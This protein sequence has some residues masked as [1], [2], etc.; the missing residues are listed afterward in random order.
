MLISA[1]SLRISQDFPGYGQISIETQVFL[2]S[3]CVYRTEM[4]V[5]AQGS[6]IDGHRRAFS[7][8]FQPFS[9]LK[10]HRRTLSNAPTPSP[11]PSTALQLGNSPANS[12][13]PKETS[14]LPLRLGKTEDNCEGQQAVGWERE[15]GKGKW[16]KSAAKLKRKRTFLGVLD[17]AISYFAGSTANSSAE[18]ASKRPISALKAHFQCLEAENESLL[19]A[20]STLQ[21]QHQLYTQHISSLSATLQ[22][23]QLRLEAENSVF[24]PM[25]DTAP[26]RTIDSPQGYSE[27]PNIRPEMYSRHIVNRV[28]VLL[29]SVINFS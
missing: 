13:S 24:V 23:L 11:V 2:I 25:E 14:E 19:L 28:P 16:G 7:T 27:S 26:R 3:E 5:S 29:S 17:A 22:S 18:I 8:A 4:A 20:R 9:S 6:G 21:S 15:R 12:E 1:S 10:A